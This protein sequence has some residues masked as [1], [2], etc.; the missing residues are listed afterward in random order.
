ML[1]G[2]YKSYCRSQKLLFQKKIF[3]SYK[4][5][6]F[7]LQFLILTSTC[8]LYAPFNMGGFRLDRVCT[9]HVVYHQELLSRVVLTGA[10][11]A[12]LIPVVMVTGAGAV[13]AITEPGFS[14]GLCALRRHVAR[15]TE[16]GH[17]CE[18]ALLVF[19]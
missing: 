18:Q 15:G 19:Y 7:F 4:I 9:K 14:H 2:A 13:A 16:P 12:P 8:H 5:Q 11:P 17:H 6:I 3:P 1:K 10:R